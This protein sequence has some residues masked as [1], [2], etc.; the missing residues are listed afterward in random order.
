MPVSVQCEVC[1]KTQSVRPARAKIYRFCSYE[2]RGKWRSE[3]WTGDNNPSWQ[4]NQAREKVCAGC[5]ATYGPRPKQPITTF[6]HQKFCCKPCAD[7]HG[8]RYRG[9]DN[10]LYRRDA[11]RRNKRRGEHKA[12]AQKVISRDGAICQR[13][14]ASEVE[15]HAHHI[16]PF[17]TYPDL[18]YVVE[19]GLTLCAPCHWSVHAASDANGVNSGDALTVQAEGNPEPSFGGNVVEGVTTR[20]RAYRRWE[21]NCDFCGTFLSKRLS[22]ALASKTHFCNKSCSARYHRNGVKRHGPRQ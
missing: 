18:R 6:K 12:W 3:N 2:C 10:V 16:K 8:V 11:L 19:N 15:L 21:G 9:P 17:E 20:G 22:D 5:G 13:C 14:G 4:E 1:G 7:K